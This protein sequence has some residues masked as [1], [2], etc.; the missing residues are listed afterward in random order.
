MFDT[1]DSKHLGLLPPD[2]LQIIV[3]EP[4]LQSKDFDYIRKSYT[5]SIEEV[6]TPSGSSY[7]FHPE[8]SRNYVERISV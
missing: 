7:V 4:E 6:V 8:E 1:F 2:I 3:R 5:K